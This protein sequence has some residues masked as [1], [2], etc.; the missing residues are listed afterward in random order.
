MVSFPGEIVQPRRQWDKRER[1]GGMNSTSLVE[2]PQPQE[3]TGAFGEVSVPQLYLGERSAEMD[4]EWLSGCKSR[5]WQTDRSIGSAASIIEISQEIK[6]SREVRALR[7]IVQ[8]LNESNSTLSEIVLDLSESYSALSERV[9]KLSESNSAL[10]SRVSA[11]EEQLLKKTTLDNLWEISDKNLK[12]L[13]E[14]SGFTQA[15]GKSI[16]QNP[17]DRLK[18]LLKEYSDDTVDSVEL[19]HSIRR[20]K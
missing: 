9:Q 20:G 8:E 6:A 19:I 3:R 11:L 4:Q 15:Q 5:S 13:E 17:F 16:E 18:G 12:V 7:E 10:Q 1:H 2:G 14:I